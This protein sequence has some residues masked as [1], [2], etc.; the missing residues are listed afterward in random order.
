MAPFTVRLTDRSNLPIATPLRL[1]PLRYAWSDM[2]GPE[3]AEIALDGMP[4]DMVGALRWLGGNVRIV[5]EDGT[6]V[7]WGIITEASFTADGMDYGLTLDGM[8]NRVAVIY[9]SNGSAALT[10][11]VEDTRSTDLYGDIELIH[12]LGN[13]TPAQAEAMADSILAAKAWPRRLVRVAT[14]A[15]GTGRL[16]CIGKYMTMGSRYYANSIGRVAFEGEKEGE[17]ILGWGFASSQLVGFHAKVGRICQLSCAMTGLRVDDKIVVSGSTSNNG[18]FTVTE[19]AG[20]TSQVVYGGANG[21]SFEVT[22]D[23]KDT[24]DLLDQFTAGEM[25][26][27]ENSSD[28]DGF[29]FWRT[30]GPEACTVRPN[31]IT[32]ESAEGPGGDVLLTQGNSVKVAETLTQEGPVLGSKFVTIIAHGQEV[33]QTFTVDDGGTWTVGEVTLWVRRVGTP[34][35]SLQVELCADS[36]GAPGTVLDTATV[37]GSSLPTRMTKLQI[38]MNRTAT[39]SNGT[40]HIVISRTGANSNSAYYMVAVDEEAGYSGGVMK[41]YTGSA[42]A[43]RVV[44][45]DLH[46]EVWGHRETTAIVDEIASAYIG[47]ASIRT[48]AG[49]YD[50]MYRAGTKTALD[51]VERLLDAGTSTGARLLAMVSVDNVLIVEA[52]P[53]TAAARWRDGRFT[54]MQGQPLAR[55]LLPV[56]QWVALD[57]P[58][59]DD[60]APFSPLWLA[61]CEYD[62]D[63]DTLTPGFEDVSVWQVGDLD[64]G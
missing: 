15:N 38:L 21:V 5:G 11:W 46:F 54:S 40:Y 24:N 63:G 26:R 6:P 30:V 32:A 49:V 22:D 57:V 41:L 47:D 42:W 33:D 50:R 23:I 8:A 53:T 27:V 45:A 43:S 58:I 52:A 36:S 61:R 20:L 48:A 13:G 16:L 31:S 19:E 7:W 44:D 55:G 2:G 62:V 56:G 18:T 37:L 14:G 3:T 25:F 9:T 4:V 51:E 29:W 39:L 59:D 35:D 10:D 60:R 28:N 64:E 34:G 17:A 1:R 12:S